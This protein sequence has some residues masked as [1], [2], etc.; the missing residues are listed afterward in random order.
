MKVT[1]RLVCLG[2][3]LAMLTSTQPFAGDITFDAVESKHWLTVN[4]NVMGGISY[5]HFTYH[6]GYSTFSGYLSLENNG[7]FASV[8]RLISPD[9]SAA[10]SIKL[11]IK[12]DGRRYQFRL[13]THNL[14][15]GAAYVAEFTTTPNQW[16]TVQFSEADFSPRY[17]G[18]ALSS[19]PALNFSDAMQVSLLIAD[20]KAGKFRLSI[21]SIQLLQSI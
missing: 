5:S 1:T 15:E 21:K 8:R 4:D 12:G 2:F 6:Q 9:F 7:G 20:K 16:Q 17:R 19:M 10:S 11:I 13:K 3:F 14:Y 18:K